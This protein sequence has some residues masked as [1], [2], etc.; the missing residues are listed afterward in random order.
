MRKST[1]ILLFVCLCLCSLHNCGKEQSH[2]K[3]AVQPANQFDH[4]ND[5]EVTL[6]PIIPKILDRLAPDRLRGNIETLVSFETRHIL[7]DTTSEKRGIGAAR[8]WIY[9]ELKRY[10]EECGGRLQLQYDKWRQR[11][12]SLGR[13]TLVNITAWLPGKSLESQDRTVI[14]CAHYDSRASDG[15][16]AG[17]AAPGA[18]DN[19]SGVSVVMEMARLFSLYQFET[20]ILFA[21]LDGSEHGLF[22]STR[23]A[24]RAQRDGWQVDAVLSLDAVGNITAANGAVDSTS[25][26]CFSEGIPY[27]ETP[28]QALQRKINGGAAD[29]PSRQ[30]A[31]YIRRMAETYIPDFNVS[32]IFRPDA[33]GHTGDHLVFNKVGYAAVGLTEAVDNS[34]FRQQN[35]RIEDGKQ[36]GDLPEYISLSYLHKVAQVSAATLAGLALA[37]N[38]PR[39]VTINRENDHDTLLTFQNLSPNSDLAA[40]KILVRETTAPFWQKQ[41]VF[42]NREPLIECTLRNITLDNYFFAISTV[43]RDGNESIPVFPRLL[44]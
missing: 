27:L 14:F 38:A 15:R 33:I 17:I 30:L 23:L 1:C 24:E 9:G 41:I 34:H 35:V 43:D 25:L 11:S 4:L 32:L 7:S 44:Q 22:G 18:N 40:Y 8:R 21:I 2:Q 10:K 42:T 20:N 12:D 36:F 28:E 13:V 5:A 37:P 29:A 3:P 39:E 31:R 26:R 19:G 6:N 16:N